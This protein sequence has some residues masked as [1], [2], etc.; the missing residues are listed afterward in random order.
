MSFFLF[1]DSN[2]GQLGGKSKLAMTFYSSRGIENFFYCLSE[3]QL[4]RFCSALIDT[5]GIDHQINNC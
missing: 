5:K 2:P 3:L 1:R 4:K